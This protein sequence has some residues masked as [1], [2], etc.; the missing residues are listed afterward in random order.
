MK[1][2]KTEGYKEKL[3]QER[4][5]IISEIKQNE[6]PVNFGTDTDHGDEETDKS[7]EMGSQMAMAEDLKM[8]LSEIDE[9]LAKIQSGKYGI[10]ETCHKEI[11]EEILDIDPESR[12]CKNCKASK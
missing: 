7:E 11:E 3:Q 1:Q 6:R 4:A 8:R 12:L 5:L 10:C 2:E 9:A